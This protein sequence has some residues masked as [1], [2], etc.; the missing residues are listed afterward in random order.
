MP[1]EPQIIFEDGGGTGVVSFGDEEGGDEGESDEPTVSNT[2]EG[3]T[4][5]STQNEDGSWDHEYER[6]LPDGSSLKYKL[7]PDDPNYPHDDIRFRYGRDKD[8]DKDKPIVTD[9]GDG[10]TI[11]S[12]RLKDGT[13]RH[14]YS[15]ED[16]ERWLEY[17]LKPD[18][19]RYPTGPPF[20]SDDS[21]EEDIEDENEVE[22]F[23]QDSEGSQ[24]EIETE[25]EDQEEQD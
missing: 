23:D 3:G 2:P 18:D 5:T 21:S 1:L 19:P 10:G 17:D 16:D 7:K 4:I 20:D 25:E 13:W 22:G 11:T 8:A 6:D 14:R 12:I 9:A 24:D 15:Y